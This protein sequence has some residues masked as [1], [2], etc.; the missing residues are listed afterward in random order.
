MVEGAASRAAELA[1]SLSATHRWCS[2]GTP[3]SKGLDDLHGL[4]AFL[5]AEPYAQRRWWEALVTRP[6]AG[7]CAGAADL[8]RGRAWRAALRL[9][10]PASPAG[11]MWRNTKAHL[12]AELGVP[13]QHGHVRRLDLSPIEA[14]FYARQHADCLQRARGALPR[15]ALEPG[16]SGPEDRLLTAREEKRVLLPL[17]R[18]RQACCHPQV[19]VAAVGKGGSGMSERRGPRAMLKGH[20]TSENW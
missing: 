13:R 18:L 5:G 12:G 10:D 14:H 16:G 6:L 7:A 3:L 1:R 8:E 19:R 11:L 2:T 20:G 4:L 15:A 9:L 17:L